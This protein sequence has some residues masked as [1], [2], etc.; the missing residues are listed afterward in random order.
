MMRRHIGWIMT[1]LV[2]ALFFIGQA[3]AQTYLH[4]D[5]NGNII[6][7]SSQANINQLSRDISNYNS[8]RAG[9][10]SSVSLGGGM[11]TMERA[12]TLE[13]G[14][15]AG[16]GTAV[17]VAVRD[18]VTSPISS[19]G[20]G[21]VNVARVSPAGLAG[22]IAASMLLDAGIRWANGQ[23]TK[24]GTPEQAPNGKPYP[25]AESFGYMTGSSS[26]AVTGSAE[27]ACMGQV[28]TEARLLGGRNYLYTGLGTK[29]PSTQTCVFTWV[30]ANPAR[31]GLT[32]T[33]NRYSNIC[34]SGA[35]RNGDLCYPPGYVP[36]GQTAPATDAQIESA[37]TQGL[38]KTPGVAMD[39]MKNIYDNG[40]WVP[41]DVADSAGWTLPSTPVKGQ[42][43]SSVS[44]STAPNGDSITTTKTTTPTLNLGTGG[45]T[46]GNNT[47][48]WNVTNNTTTTV[49]NNTTGQTSTST[50]QE[51]APIQFNDSA[52]PDVPQ[53]YTQKYPDGL[54]GVWRD[55]KPDISNTAFYNGVKTMFPT[56]GAGQCPVWRMSF[57]LGAAG[58]FGSGDLTVPCW[59][60]QAL[61]LVILA[62]AAFT[63]RKIIF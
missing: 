41:L 33:V 61:G 3:R 14:A 6:G 39:V 28:A 2:L 55:N 10:P 35:V 26:S 43:S 34:L 36:P 9:A 7:S 13:V 19:L 63:A 38:G 31:P 42:P 56:F 57:N 17:K 59:I 48:T 51:D 46:A 40:G 12:A 50:D 4:W 21:I 27:D 54:A 24:D 49:T 23:W 25:F 62:T 44:N 16:L 20:K 47:I 52:M 45:N 30:D 22:S 5:S 60:F 29:N 1:G 37:I 32:T 8:A 58:N 11:A 15:G 18:V 53:L